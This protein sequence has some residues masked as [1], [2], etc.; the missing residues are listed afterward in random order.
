MFD[1]ANANHCSNCSDVVH[2]D[3][4]Y[5][6]AEDV[7]CENC[8][9]NHTGTCEMC[10]ERHWSNDLENIDTIINSSGYSLCGDICQDCFGDMTE[11][12]NC[13]A[14]V[15]NGAVI[16]I[17]GECYCPEC[18]DTKQDELDKLEAENA[19]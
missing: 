8:F 9:Y 5:I 17:D 10:G 12:Y 13:G 1:N 4:I 6:F 7:W 19:E 14:L 15:D 3:D 11:C 2:D 18:G 16:C